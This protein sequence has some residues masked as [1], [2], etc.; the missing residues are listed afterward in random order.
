MAHVTKRRVMI[1]LATL[2]IVFSLLVAFGPLVLMGLIPYLPPAPDCD[3]DLS[4][5]EIRSLVIQD[6]HGLRREQEPHYRIE[7]GIWSIRE[8]PFKQA[9]EAD[10]EYDMTKYDVEVSFTGAG[11]EALVGPCGETI[12]TTRMR[13]L[14]PPDA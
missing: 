2:L 11:F 13:P 12:M 5:A 8:Q 3:I 7:D 1:A 6:I 4:E 9:R 10:S 14:A